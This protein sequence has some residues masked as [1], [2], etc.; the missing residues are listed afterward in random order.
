MAGSFAQKVPE[1]KGLRQ[2]ELLAGN[3]GKSSFFRQTPRPAAKRE[4]RRKPS[5]KIAFSFILFLIQRKVAW[6]PRCFTQ[7]FYKRSESPTD[8]CRSSSM[9][10]QRF[11]C[12]GSSIG[13]HWFC[14][15]KVASASL[16]LSSWV[17][18]FIIL[19]NIKKNRA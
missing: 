19:K 4:K 3:K 1:E 6:Q 13:E 10:E 12:W 11:C 9:V 14:K 8:I 17:T 18:I 16:A 2:R 5:F 7:R 15:P